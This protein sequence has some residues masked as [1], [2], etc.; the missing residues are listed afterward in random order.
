MPP[1]DLEGARKPAASAI[2]RAILCTGQ[3]IPL[4]LM[5]HSCAFASITRAGPKFAT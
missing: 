2:V 1:D 5:W 3:P 4:S